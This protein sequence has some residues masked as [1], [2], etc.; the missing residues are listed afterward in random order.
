MRAATEAI[1]GA[2]TGSLAAS[3]TVL[4]GRY[5]AAGRPQYTGH[6]S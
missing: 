3:R 1:V 2:V 6:S 4:P 5:D